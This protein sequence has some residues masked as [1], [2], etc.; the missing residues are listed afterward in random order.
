MGTECQVTVE[1]MVTEGIANS[2]NQLE[3]AGGIERLEKVK[4][5]GG[6]GGGSW[7]GDPVSC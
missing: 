2:C 1:D 7:E 6:L 5:C 3:K 4:G